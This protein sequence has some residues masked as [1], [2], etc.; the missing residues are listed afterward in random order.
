M[1]ECECTERAGGAKRNKT[2][3]LGIA[4]DMNEMGYERTWQQCGVKTKNIVSN[5]GKITGSSKMHAKQIELFLLFYSSLFSLQITVY[6]CA[7]QRSM[8]N[9]AKSL[10]N[11]HVNVMLSRV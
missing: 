11:G 1:V 8:Y 3:F 7:H 2:A 6:S 4:K 9:K 10:F 5:Y